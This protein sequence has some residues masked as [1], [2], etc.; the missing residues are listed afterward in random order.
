MSA[1]GFILAVNGRSNAIISSYGHC[2]VIGSEAMILI[3]AGYIMMKWCALDLS[4]AAGP[5]TAARETN[6][7]P[8][9]YIE[10][11]KKKKGK[12]KA[13]N[14]EKIIPTEFSRD[15]IRVHSFISNAME[16]REN[17][18]IRPCSGCSNRG[19]PVP[20]WAGRDASES[21]HKRVINAS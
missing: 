6:Y 3:A 1:M 17:Q 21:C 14:E 12:K 11:F 8:K 15:Y 5:I 4:E 13:T 10:K 9:K 7:I 18:M 16:A 19:R 2:Y 20:P